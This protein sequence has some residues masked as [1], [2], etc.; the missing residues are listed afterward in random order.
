MV[1]LYSVLFA[2]SIVLQF[3]ASLAM[4]IIRVYIFLCVPDNC[5]HVFCFVILRF[6]YKAC[7]RPTAVHV[8][9]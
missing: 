4:Y 2:V 6:L 7:H 8:V 5:M 9:S 3:E 1:K